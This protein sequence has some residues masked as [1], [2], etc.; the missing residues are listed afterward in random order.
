MDDRIEA[1]IRDVLNLEGANSNVVR[2]GV[3]RHLPQYEKL[4]RDAEPDKRKKDAAAE[5]F[6]KLCRDRVLKQI[7]LR[8][9]PSTVAHLQ[10][11]LSMIDAQCVP[12]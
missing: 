3:R 11:V 8:T 9:T 5:R 10:I 2:E 4:F 7:Q 6:H 1:F 12:G